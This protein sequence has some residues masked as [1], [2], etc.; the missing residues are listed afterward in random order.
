[1]TSPDSCPSFFAGPKF[2]E[3]SQAKRRSHPRAFNK[4]KRFLQTAGTAPD[5]KAGPGVGETCVKGFLS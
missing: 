1:M 3:E 5:P 4:A 2:A